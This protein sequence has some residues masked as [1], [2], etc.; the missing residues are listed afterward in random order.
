MKKTVIALTLATLMTSQLTACMGQMGLSGM[1]TKANLSVVDN[2]YARAGLY[3]LLAPAY[4]L[5]ATADLF[6]FNSVEFWTGTNPITGKSPAVV[7]LPVEA[8]FKVNQHINQELTDAPASQIKLT[9]A[10]MT[11]VDAQTLAMMLTYEDGTT[12]LM[13]GKKDGEMVDFYLDKQLITRVSLNELVAYQQSK[14]V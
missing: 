8:I 1:L 3:M 2:R 9:K 4:G 14:A 7:D 5:T 12:Q 11:S 13:E 6:I 10:T